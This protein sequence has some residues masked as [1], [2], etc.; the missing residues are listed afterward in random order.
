ME[1]RISADLPSTRKLPP[2]GRRGMHGR[3]VDVSL[4]DFCSATTSA[5][6]YANTICQNC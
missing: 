5:P 1:A 6:P 4:A 2:D 3:L